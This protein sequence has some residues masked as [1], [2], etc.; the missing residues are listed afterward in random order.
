MLSPACNIIRTTLSCYLHTLGYA[1][2]TEAAEYNGSIVGAT[3]VEDKKMCSA[4]AWGMRGWI[5]SCSAVYFLPHFRLMAQ[6]C[7]HRFTVRRL[8]QETDNSC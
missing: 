7:T 2:S 1:C 3:Q 6:A 5:N 8:K 4:S